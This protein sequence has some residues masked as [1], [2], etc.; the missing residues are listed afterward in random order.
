VAKPPRAVAAKERLHPSA[1]MIAALSSC[2]P[3]ACSYL[4]LIRTYMLGRRCV[5]GFAG[6]DDPGSRVVGDAVAGVV[7]GERGAGVCGRRRSL[8]PEPVD[9]PAVHAVAQDLRGRLVA[10][11]RVERVAVEGELVRPVGA[12]HHAE[13]AHHASNVPGSPCTGR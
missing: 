2:T 12:H 4:V 5:A 13:G 9:V 8:V 6:G 7:G 1:F 10:L 3:R 11:V